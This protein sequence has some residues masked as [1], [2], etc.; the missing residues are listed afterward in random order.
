[1]TGPFARPLRLT[2]TSALE[3]LLLRLPADEGSDFFATLTEALG[4][5]LDVTAALVAEPVGRPPERAR[6]LAMWLQGGRADDVEYRLAGSPCAQVY[7][8]GRVARPDRVRE[9][10]P[11]FALLQRL[12]VEGYWGIGIPGNGGELLGHLALLHAGPLLLDDDLERQLHMLAVRVGEHLERRRLVRLLDEQDRH[13]Q[14]TLAHFPGILYQFVVATDG[15]VGFTYVSPRFE[16]FL[17]IRIDDALA[18]F[19]RTVEVVHPD[20]RDGLQRAI[21]EAVACVG[22]FDWTGRHVV[23][24]SIRYL[25]WRSL[26]TRLDDGTI[27]WAGH[28]TDETELR[29]TELELQ[30]VKD[31]HLAAQRAA[32]I[33]NWELDLATLRLR[34]S[35]NQYEL[36]GFD[37]AAGAPSL[38]TVLAL[39][40]D[41]DQARMEDRVRRLTEAREPFEFEWCITRPDG[42]RRH[43]QCR[44]TP[45]LDE[46]GNVAVITGTDLDVTREVAAREALRE[47]EEKLRHAQKLDAIG[48]LAGGVA[49]DFNNLL[50]AMLGFSQLALQKIENGMDARGDLREVV[51]SVE[52]ASELTT[53][54]VTIGRR[55]VVCIQPVD[56][57]RVVR[58]MEPVLWRTLGEDVELSVHLDPLVGSIRADVSGVE[59]V[60]LNL[61]VNARDAMPQGGRLR[62]EVRRVRR[63]DVPQAPPGAPTDDLVGL[64][65]TDTGCGM[66]REQLSHVF[67]PFFTT[68]PKGTG[69]GLATVYGIVDRFG[70]FVTVRS[71]P[72]GGAC[73]GLYFPFDPDTRA[74]VREPVR[75][76]ADRGSETILVVE[77]D[78]AVRR[79]VEQALSRLGYRVLS[80]SNGIEA[81]ALLAGEQ[82]VDL[83]LTDVVMPQ[84]GGP[85]LVGRARAVRP[86]LRCLYITGFSPDRAVGDDAGVHGVLMKPFTVEQLAARLRDALAGRR[87]G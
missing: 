44:G 17:G 40:T 59:Q 64:T 1:M 56:L 70:G 19:G 78:R 76:G 39:A 50:T 7:V 45:I 10:Y 34:W 2:A 42:R 23:R 38:E 32:G 55:Q 81:L 13:L 82:R 66:T 61:A 8:R 60:I 3:Q 72:G 65:V 83:L 16:E 53:K 54:L 63:A 11:G 80:A 9:H 37:P 22:P 62:I 73:F 77:D 20:D 28:V 68:K 67:E 12:G 36:Y 43:I 84:M 47:S 74:D 52:R 49:H 75:D 41:D 33:G 85:A 48:Q 18:D 29:R 58:D 5:A 35:E 79:F 69:L 4:R 86:E 30:A 24:G 71:S 27:R 25:R 87:A 51:K 6:T 14:E 21:D 46:H 26:P 15:S 57:T 31:R